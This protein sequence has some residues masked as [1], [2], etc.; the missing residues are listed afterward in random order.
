[1]PA[2]TEAIFLKR[3]LNTLEKGGV[4]LLEAIREPLGMGSKLRLFF[5]SGTPTDEF[6][7]GAG[8]VIEHTRT[9]GGGP[10]LTCTADTADDSVVLFSGKTKLK[11]QPQAAE[12]NLFSDL[13][14]LLAVR[15]G[16]SS[17]VV[18]EWLNFHVT[19]HDAEAA[20]I[21]NRAKPLT[22][23]NF[24][25]QLKKQAGSIQGLKMLVV[26][27]ADVPLGQPDLAAESHPFNVPGAPG[28]DRMEV[29]D[30]EPWQAPLGELL[31]YE[32][33][34]ARFLNTARAVANIDVYDLLALDDS[35]NI[36]DR[37]VNST[38]GTLL[39]EG[40]QIY[41]WRIRNGDSGR[42]GDHICAQ[43]DNENLRK[44]WCVAPKRLGENTV[45]RLIRI[46]GSNPTPEESTRF[47]RCM[48]LRHPAKSVSKIVPK[49]SLT[50][51]SALVDQAT[52]IFN[53]K[54]V[55]AP[56]VSLANS[57]K[58]KFGN[59]TGGT[60]TTIVTTMKNEGPFILEWIAYH[61][62]IG[63]EDFLIYTNDCT[64]G[65]ETMLE[66]LQNKGI[67]QHRENPFSPS[68]DLKP[69]HAA[70]QAAEMEEVV[71]E[72]DWLICMDVDEFINIHTGSGKLSDLFNA[73]KNANMISLTW[74]L[75]G[76][77]DIHEY[78]DSPICEAFTHCAPQ[79]SRKPHQAWGFKTLFRNLAI[80]KKLGVHRPKGLKP[81]L[82][83]D[84]HWVNGSGKAMP[85]SMYR[86]GWRSTMS[87]YGYNLVTLNHYAVR[88]AE[89]FL[90]KRDRG[91]VNHVD[92]DQ[93]LSYWFRMNNNAE[94]DLS[95][96]RMLPAMRAEL[97]KLMADPEIATAH[98]Y[99]VNKH[100]EKIGT[101]KATNA[102]ANFYKDL[103][104]RRLEKLSRL[105]TN[106][107]AN[108]FLMGPDV[109]PEE[110]SEADPSKPFLF[111]V[112]KGET[113]H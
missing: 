1:M 56:V 63:V 9:I 35:E 19:H 13:N 81:Q 98:D 48:A 6:S 17:E 42:F 12:T 87:T 66:L 90:V 85:Q 84:I 39:L 43:F 76:N 21:I 89:S 113:S 96:Q 24:F 110:I 68:G 46:V 88:S 97:D 45:W 16:E 107:G 53:H 62:A 37:A 82:Y 111:T 73:T 28:K 4:T 30:P 55:R 104:G 60:R 72:S 69:Q 33:V 112:E 23:T 58:E 38:T 41:P 80:F 105:H 67:V 27:D 99:S 79:L 25:N 31:I 102:Y 7:L 106:F 54:P 103:T 70:L 2:P 10:M 50:E 64:D 47:Y 57:G 44:R 86:N 74:R 20:L 51:N 18:A 75:F 5:K 92:R 29:P 78:Q 14:T 93:G 59:K 83:E 71:K 52:K 26:L 94:T 34:R 61:R 8:F 95:I 15:N 77:S 91:R 36:F 3:R 108:V 109:I 32:L 40:V 11:I 101:L 65:T 49:T 22:D 100:R